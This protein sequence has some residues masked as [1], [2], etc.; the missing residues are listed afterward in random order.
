MLT[1]LHLALFAV[2]AVIAAAL[3]VVSAAGLV[4]GSYPRLWIDRLILAG[5]AGVAL[6]TVVGPALI[7][8]GE[9]PS[10]GLHFLYAAVAW[11]ALPV[12]RA[13]SG[14]MKTARRRGTAIV[15]AAIVLLGVLLRLYMTGTGA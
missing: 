13:V 15:V 5:L 2:T 12:G 11:L 6:T 4:S 10:D 3:L 14:S 8:S 1:Q 7:L 9:Q